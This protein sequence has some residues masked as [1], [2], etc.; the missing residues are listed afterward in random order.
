MK[1]YL[2]VV[3]AI[4]ML[5]SMATT[6]FAAENSSGDNEPALDSLFDLVD[7]ISFAP[8]GTTATTNNIVV[9]GTISDVDKILALV[10]DG[11]VERGKNGELPAK[12]VVTQIIDNSAVEANYVL[13]AAS[14]SATSISITKS[15][16][17]Y[18][19]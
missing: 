6:A 7:E 1:K 17:G 19:F 14:T 2:S 5:L 4:V 18:R 13:P 8:Q 15:N 11:T 3:L 10:N 16:L 12:I 9:T